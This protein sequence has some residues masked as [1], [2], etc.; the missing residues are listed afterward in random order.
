MDGSEKVSKRIIIKNFLIIFVILILVSFIVFRVIQLFKRPIEQG[1]HIKSTSHLKQ[2]GLAMKQYALDNNDV[3]PFV[4]DDME[5]YQALGFLHPSYASSLE[6]FRCPSA[7]DEKWDINKSHQYN[8]RDGAP[9]TKDA[10]AKSLSYAY[11]FNKDGNGKGIRGPWNE[12]DPETV[13]IASDKY[14]THD[15]SVDPDSKR[16]PSNHPIERKWWRYRGGRH[17]VYLDGSA[18]WEEIITPLDVDPKTEYENS[19]HP[20]SDQTDADWWSDPPEKK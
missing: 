16:R 17:V 2:I 11:S 15:Y 20:E 6:V 5:P 9:F 4:G 1:G 14:V 8:N 10:C 7:R 13:R 19:G 12:S 18:K 3:Y